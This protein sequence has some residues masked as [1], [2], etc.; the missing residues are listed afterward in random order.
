[1]DVGAGEAVGVD[2]GTRLARGRVPVVEVAGV[3]ETAAVDEGSVHAGFALGAGSGV[4]ASTTGNT[5]IIAFLTLER[6]GIFVVVIST[7]VLAEFSGEIEVNVRN[8]AVPGFDVEHIGSSSVEP[9][10]G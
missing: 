7:G 8:S 4:G 10:I 5:G 6:G 3:A 2:G 1:M 9:T